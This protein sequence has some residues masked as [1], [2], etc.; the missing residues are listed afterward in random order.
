MV[1][2]ENERRDRTFKATESVLMRQF[3]RLDLVSLDVKGGFDHDGDP[4]LHVT[5]IYDAENTELE[6][7]SLSGLV[8]HLRRALA[9]HG[10]DRFPVVSFIDAE[11]SAEAA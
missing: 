1:D 6:A 3:A 8:R 11:E 4:I 7:S 9:E 2:A 10:E 5:V